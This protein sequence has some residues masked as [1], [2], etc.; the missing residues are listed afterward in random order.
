METVSIQL[1]VKQIEVVKTALG[2]HRKNLIARGKEAN[3]EV[4][5]FLETE[6][7]PVFENY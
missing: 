2:Q 5:N 6:V 7:I 4:I 3:K 1:T